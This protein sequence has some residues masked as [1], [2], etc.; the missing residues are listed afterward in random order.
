M[1]GDLV[2]TSNLCWTFA[3][4]GRCPRGAACRWS[5]ERLVKDPAD[6]VCRAWQLW[7]TCPRGDECTWHHP[8]V[9]MRA[10]P[11]PFQNSWTDY[12]AGVG[13]DAF[14]PWCQDL[15]FQANIQGSSDI[16]PPANENGSKQ[17]Q[18]ILSLLY[19]NDGK[20]GVANDVYHKQQDVKESRPL[21]PWQPSDSD[22]CGNSAD[23]STTC[24][25]SSPMNLNVVLEDMPDTQGPWDQFEVNEKLF[26]VKTS[27]HDDLSQYTTK[28]KMSEIPTSVRN[29]AERIAAQIESEHKASGNLD[30]DG[31]RCEAAD[32]GI[33]DE[34][35]Q[36]SAVH[37]R[38]QVVQMQ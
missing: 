24:S 18:Q 14:A 10:A 23:E 9:V 33:L 11:P 20:D 3:Q 36:F 32:D 16:H 26:C 29:K 13:N 31:Y 15:G 2:D 28:L 17:G 8:P 25:M 1:G 21:Q 6:T 19:A 22:K 5:H 7:G 35:A 37:C 34:E 4:T 12:S 30:G 27:F 38:K